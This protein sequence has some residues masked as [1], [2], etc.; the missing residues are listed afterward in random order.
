[1]LTDIIILPPKRLRNLVGRRL[2]QATKALNYYYLVD[3]RKLVPH[4]SLLHLRISKNRLALLEKVIS[5]IASKH[6]IFHIRSIKVGL[7]SHNATVLN[8]FFSKASALKKLNTEIVQKCSKLRTGNLFWWKDLHKFSKQDR[9]YIY[10]YG[11]TWSVEKN[12]KPHFTLGRMASEKSTQTALDRIKD[13][14]VDFVADT[15]ALA[16]INNNG[17]V[18]KVLKTFKLKS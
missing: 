16:A 1:M 13:L 18:T 9:K 7:Y 4:L 11:T 3:N 8:L 14:E 2:R 15:V 10:K 17:Q 5:N 12:F 6:R